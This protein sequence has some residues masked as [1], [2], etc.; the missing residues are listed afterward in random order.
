MN[1]TFLLMAEFESPTIP[2][3]KIRKRYFNICDK[4]NADRAARNHTL[5]IPAFKIGG[6]KSEWHVHI[7]DLAK[8]IDKVNAEQKLAWEKINAA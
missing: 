4:K 2:L 6:P 3:E 8:H 7:D 1:T 5:P